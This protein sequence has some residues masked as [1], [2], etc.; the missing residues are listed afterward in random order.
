MSVATIFDA[1][2]TNLYDGV[3]VDEVRKS[4]ILA[5]RSL[6]LDPH[7]PGVQRSRDACF[8]AQSDPETKRRI[9]PWVTLAQV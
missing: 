6:M 7:F 9:E 3:P 2:L 4:A 1:T 8:S 5:A